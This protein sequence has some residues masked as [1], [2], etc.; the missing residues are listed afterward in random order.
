MPHHV[1]ELWECLRCAEHF[2]GD[3]QAIRLRNPGDS[4]A[5]GLCPRC[6]PGLAAWVAECDQ[7]G[8]IGRDGE[9]GEVRECVCT[10]CDVHFFVPTARGA[11]LF[12]PK[13]RER[14]DHGEWLAAQNAVKQER[15]KWLA[16]LFLVASVVLTILVARWLPRSAIEYGAGATFWAVAGIG[17]WVW[18]RTT[19]PS[20]RA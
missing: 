5:A 14:D 19:D 8:G 12:C 17:Y 13:C 18:R 16:W 10:R 1:A 9:H 7:R 4:L 2:E 15:G 11:E 3:A 20:R 6:R